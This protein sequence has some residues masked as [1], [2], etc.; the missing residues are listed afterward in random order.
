MYIRDLPR[1]FQPGALVWRD[2]VHV[3]LVS[4]Y[5]VMVQTFPI[6]A[7]AH[8]DKTDTGHLNVKVQSLEEFAQGREVKYEPAAAPV[9]LGEMWNRVSAV[10]QAKLPFGLFAFGEDWNCESFARYV[11]NGLPVSEQAEG[12]KKFLG[13]AALV[14]VVLV[15]ASSD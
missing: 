5:G 3:G 1:D 8:I 9:P 11:K 14:G 12:F 15:L 7:V 10:A 13:V 4:H 6:P 2:D